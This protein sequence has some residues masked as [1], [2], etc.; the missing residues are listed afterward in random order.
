MEERVP[1]PGYAGYSITP[2][3]K[4]YYNGDILKVPIKRPGRAF[5]IRIGQNG[6]TREHG[7]AILVAKTFVPNPCSYKK[8][9]FKDG[10]KYNYHAGN[11]QWVSNIE[12]SRYSLF[13]GKPLLPQ[14]AVK[15]KPPPKLKAVAA[16]RR[17][18]PQVPQLP[19]DPCCIPLPGFP[20][21][22]INPSGEVYSRSRRLTPLKSS[23]R[24]DRYK[25]KDEDGISARHTIFRLLALA[26][27]PNPNGYDKIIFKDRDR[28]N[29]AVNNLQWVSASALREHYHYKAIRQPVQLHPGSVPVTGYPGYFISPDGTVYKGNRIIKPNLKKGKS[30]KVRLRKESR[31]YTLGLATLLANH[32]IPNPRRHRYI[33]FK[34]RNNNNCTIENIA[35]VDAQTFIYYCGILAGRSKVVLQR[36][37]AAKVCTCPLLK[38]YYKTLDTYWLDECWKEIQKRIHVRD[39]P[40]L[41]AECY[42]YFIDRVKRFSLLR[43][44]VGLLL[45]YMKGLRVKLKKEIS[46]NIP[47]KLL[48]ST[49]ESLRNR[50]C[51]NNYYD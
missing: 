41:A 45:F 37:E 49:D 20:G 2:Q 46:P 42:L 10:N 12:Y 18:R 25:L 33:I 28:S 32:F 9:I 50:S 36:E 29:L 30:P 19:A 23:G 24:S 38:R 21:Y 22:Y 47:V 27:V 40:Q 14:P 5:K 8:I 51:N 15:I 35:W 26:F 34:D 4:V 44:P 6:I 11:I 39:W 43:D 13:P 16:A 7:L 48:L 17:V 3:G 31:Q 1:L